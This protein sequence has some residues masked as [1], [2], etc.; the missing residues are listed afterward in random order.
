MKALHLPAAARYGRRLKQTKQRGDMAQEFFSQ[1]Q[2]SKMADVIIES[3]GPYAKGDETPTKDQIIPA[4]NKAVEKSLE[5]LEKYPDE[6]LAG[7]Y[8]LDISHHFDAALKENAHA[9]TEPR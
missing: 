8:K 4:I 3:W 6:Y 2:L 7:G 5:S 1:E 9:S